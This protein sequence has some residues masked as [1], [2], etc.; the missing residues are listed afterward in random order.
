MTREDLEDEVEAL[1]EHTRRLDD[2][3]GEL[4]RKNALVIASVRA[5]VSSADVEVGE[6][7][8][9]L[10]AM[11]EAATQVNDD[12]EDVQT[13]VSAHGEQLSAIADVGGKKTS[14]DE[15]ITAIATFAMRKSDSNSSKVL[16]DAGEIQGCVD[17]SRRY[18]YD[19]I[20]DLAEDDR[21]EWASL[22]K[23]E[24]VPTHKGHREKKKALRVDVDVL[25]ESSQDQGVVN[26][27]TT[28]SPT[29]GV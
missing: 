21:A 27:F 19:L 9:P 2:R 3:I 28:R 24:S 6:D 14:K 25:R 29:G 17:C 12:F 1:R 18:A 26:K 5:L 10:V 8:D 7:D 15:K 23:A 22:Q 4:D 20:D 11:R 13:A 16:V